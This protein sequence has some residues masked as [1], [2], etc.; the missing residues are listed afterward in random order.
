MG[1]PL[2]VGGLPPPNPALP[3]S[4]RLGLYFIDQF[5]FQPIP[6][7]LTTTVVRSLIIAAVIIGIRLYDHEFV[8]TTP[9]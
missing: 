3:L 9:V 5:D 8:I 6:R 7:P 1:G 4:C 2:L